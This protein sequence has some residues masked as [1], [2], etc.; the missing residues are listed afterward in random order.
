MTHRNHPLPRLDANLPRMPVSAMLVATLSGMVGCATNAMP[1]GLTDGQQV[2]V[3]GRVTSIDRAPW[4][5][6]GDG[7]LVLATGSRGTVTVHVPSRANLCRAQGLEVFSTVTVGM[8]VEAVG[9]ATGPTDMTV[10]VESTHRLK[11]LE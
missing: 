6:D 4:S 3:A 2:A 11:V 5:Y 10:C 8:R 9:A 1:A 7:L